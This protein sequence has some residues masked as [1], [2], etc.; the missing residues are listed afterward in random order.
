MTMKDDNDW[1]A[2]IVF[3]IIFVVMTY[4][5]LKYTGIIHYLDGLF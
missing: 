5:T 1:V 3:F 2:Y 4:V